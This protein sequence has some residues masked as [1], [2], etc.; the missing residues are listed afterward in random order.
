MA[1]NIPQVYT[2]YIYVCIHTDEER[3]REKNRERERDQAPFPAPARGPSRGSPRGWRPA[4][5]GGSPLPRSPSDAARAGRPSAPARLRVRL[6]MGSMLHYTYPACVQRAR[7]CVHVRSERLLRLGRAQLRLRLAQASALLFE[8]L[9]GSGLPRAPLSRTPTSGDSRGPIQADSRGERFPQAR[10]SP[11]ISRPGILQCLKS[12]Y[13][14]WLY[15]D[16]GF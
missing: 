4:P 12:Y 3:E 7:V 6:R 14:K 1:Q 2:T 5:R 13:V 11:R 15:R 10:G 9:V 16:P 8:P